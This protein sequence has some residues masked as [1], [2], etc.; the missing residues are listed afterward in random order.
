MKG[1]AKRTSKALS[2]ETKSSDSIRKA[3]ESIKENFEGTSRNVSTSSKLHPPTPVQAE[4]GGSQRESIQLDEIEEK[5]EKMSL[6]TIN[7]PKNLKGKGK[8]P[9]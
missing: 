2:S 6:K 5:L 4:V 9:T 1:R 7:K 3:E 8:A